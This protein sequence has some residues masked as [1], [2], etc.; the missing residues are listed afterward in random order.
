M[1]KSR[2]D[3]TPLADVILKHLDRFKAW[4]SGH[5]ASVGVPTN[6]WEIVRFSAR[7]TISVAYRNKENRVTFIGLARECWQAYVRGEDMY[8]A[9]E[10]RKSRKKAAPQIKALRARD[11]DGCFYCLLH[12]K[13]DD[14]SVEHLV[15]LVHG[16]PN[17][18]SNLALAHKKCNSDVGHLSLMEKFK[19]RERAVIQRERAMIFEGRTTEEV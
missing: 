5:G 10:R 17:H 2:T 19:V 3:A 9:G 16:G 1:K 11:G 4:L 8:L 6:E 7:N 13:E 15:A 12:V 14:A 18:L